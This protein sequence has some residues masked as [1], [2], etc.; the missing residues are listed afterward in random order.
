MNQAEVH[1]LVKALKFKVQ[2]KPFK[3]YG[4]FGGALRYTFSIKYELCHTVV[5]TSSNL[6]FFHFPVDIFCS[7]GGR[8]YQLEIYRQAV[9]ALV[10][11]ERIEMTR[12][13]G[14]MVSI[15]QLPN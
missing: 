6:I 2:P 11:N 14:M 9:T 8:R 4:E 12:H 7:R 10:V 13:K 15:F 3:I 5:K 1:H